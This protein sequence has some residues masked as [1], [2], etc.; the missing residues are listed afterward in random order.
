MLGHFL[1]E[2]LDQAMKQ[3]VVSR[4]KADSVYGN[5]NVDPAVV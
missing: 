3:S 4:R 5:R 1:K 2:G